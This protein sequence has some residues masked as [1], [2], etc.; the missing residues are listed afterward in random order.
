MVTRGDIWL[1]ALD[2]TMGSEVQKTRPCVVIS[3]PEIHHY[4][5]TVILAPMTTGNKPAP[6]RIP[7]TFEHQTGL[8]LLDQMRTLDKIQLIKKLGE[9][10]HPVL[11]ETLDILQKLFSI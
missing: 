6:Y 9:I 10:S 3:P 2:P 7:V 1:T 4:L 11:L 5:K 8:I